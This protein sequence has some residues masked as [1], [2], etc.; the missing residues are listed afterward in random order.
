MNI[1][2]FKLEQCI[3]ASAAELIKYRYED[4]Y[5]EH[6]FFN[7]IIDYIWV[8]E[9]VQLPHQ[10]FLMITFPHTLKV[11][12]RVHSMQCLMAIFLSRGHIQS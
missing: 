3:T 8:Y 5:I 12:R 6:M 2:T 10:A 1:H 11:S 4:K 9:K 7:W